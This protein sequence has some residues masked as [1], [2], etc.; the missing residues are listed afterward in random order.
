MTERLNIMVA[1]EPY[2]GT[3]YSRDYVK[4]K[5]LRQT[6]EEIE[7]MAAEMEEENAMGMGVPLETQNA[8]MQGAIDSE[9]EKQS[10]LGN[11]PKEPSL[12]NSKNGGSTKAPEINI[13]KAKI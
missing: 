8:L 10:A 1:I 3:Y 11:T 13:K 6:D 5:V 4:R 2:I 12:D 9:I 7:E